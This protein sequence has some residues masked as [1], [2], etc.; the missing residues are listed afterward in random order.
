MTISDYTADAFILLIFGGSVILFTFI[1]L[2]IIQNKTLSHKLDKLFFTSSYF[3]SFELA[4]YSHFP[5]FIWK[6]LAYIRAITFPKSMKKRFGEN[7][8]T[9]YI[10]T[11]DVINAY[12]TLVTVAFLVFT[13][14]NA[15][16]SVTVLY[17]TNQ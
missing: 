1:V 12:I 2:I 15:L 14:L 16:A 4:A 8:V 13:V 6:V 5:L 17:F 7:K 10:S 11:S 9:K 3:N